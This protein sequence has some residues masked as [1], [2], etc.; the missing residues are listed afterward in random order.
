MA[1]ESLTADFEPFV[2]MLGVWFPELPM[3]AHFVVVDASVLAE[4][5]VTRR[6]AL[7]AQ[8][9]N[10]TVPGGLHAV[11]SPEGKIAA[12][13][14]LSLYPDWE[15]IPLRGESSRRGAK[16]STPPGI[17]LSRPIPTS[18]PTSQASSA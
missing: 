16:R 2:V 4:L 17:L 5:S 7:M 14:W 8:L 18:T 11:V 3:P 15:R 12:E 1:A 6:I 9:Q 10:V 13:T